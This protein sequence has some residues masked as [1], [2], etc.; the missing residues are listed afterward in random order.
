MHLF[1]SAFFFLFFRFSGQP[2]CHSA[3]TIEPRFTLILPPL[4]FTVNQVQVISWKSRLFGCFTL[5][6][7]AFTLF[8]SIEE[9]KAIEKLSETKLRNLRDRASYKTIKRKK[10]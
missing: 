7:H 2:V 10:V 3:C 9:E 1:V 4:R 6:V 8:F 5:Y